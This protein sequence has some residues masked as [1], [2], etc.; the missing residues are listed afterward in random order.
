MYPWAVVVSAALVI[1]IIIFALYIFK[2]NS[3]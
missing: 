3:D 1:D 2:T